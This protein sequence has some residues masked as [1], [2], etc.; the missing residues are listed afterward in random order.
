MVMIVLVVLI[1]LVI[2]SMV[3][4]IPLGPVEQQTGTLTLTTTPYQ[5][6][7]ATRLSTA[8]FHA[9]SSQTKNLRVKIPKSLRQEIRPPSF[10]NSLDSN[11][12]FRD[13]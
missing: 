1:T 13:S 5:V 12:K 7:Y 4:I 11:S 3:T 6:E 10:E 8:N 9:K 2:I